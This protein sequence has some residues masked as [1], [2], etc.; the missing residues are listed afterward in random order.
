MCGA[1]AGV[2]A[3]DRHTVLVRAFVLADGVNLTKEL[4][5]G[6]TL[7][8]VP[9]AYL[10]VRAHSPAGPVVNV[11]YCLGMP[12]NSAVSIFAFADQDG[13][14]HLDAMTEPLGW[15]RNELA[16]PPLRIIVGGASAAPVMVPPFGL[17][18]TTPFIPAT[19][20]NGELRQS[21]DG[22]YHQLLLRGTAVQRAFAHGF[23]AARQLVEFFEFYI[24][25]GIV[26]SKAKYDEHY[27]PMLSSTFAQYTDPE[28]AAEANAVLAGMRARAASEGTADLLFIEALGRQFDYAELFAINAYDALDPWGCSQLIAW[29]ERT[30]DGETVTAR[31]MD[32]EI[33]VRHVTVRFLLLF[34]HQ[35]ADLGSSD[36]EVGPG[37]VS[38]MWPGHLGTFSMMTAHGLYGM[39]NAGSDRPGKPGKDEVTG[40]WAT[41]W[42]LRKTLETMPISGTAAV[43]QT[44]VTR[45]ASSAGG[46]CHPSCIFVV[47]RPVSAGGGDAGM[48]YEGDRLGGTVRLQGLVPP[49]VNNL[50]MATNH[51]LKLGVDGAAAKRSTYAGALTCC[52]GC[53]CSFSSQFRY[54]AGAQYLA[55]L[56]RD[57]R[58]VDSPAAVEW[59]TRVAH[60]TTE[61]AVVTFPAK[62]L[63]GIMVADGSQLWDAPWRHLDWV[64]VPKLLAA[65]AGPVELTV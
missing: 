55:H 5:L 7:E 24:L 25:E 37:Y 58:R 6:S 32:G 21:A 22:R 31:N 11:S 14:G 65:A 33:D 20:A 30:R 63:F 26:Q 64:D 51:F 48:I 41:T 61:H 36:Q 9:P 12:E 38:L 3:E 62:R 19:V 16:G 50:T 1:L 54:E 15:A 42:V 44:A 35:P 59:L 45:Y 23:L 56:A 13:D 17:R 47:A 57:G 2:R 8:G 60:G 43:L 53:S 49:F 52:E 39:M 4:I 28:Y 27:V 40:R 10:E 18:G 34:A 46:S 29:G